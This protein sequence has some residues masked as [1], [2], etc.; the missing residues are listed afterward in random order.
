MRRLR[1][2]PCLSSHP[3]P[4][5]CPS[6]PSHSQRRVTSSTRS[7]RCRISR[8]ASSWPPSAAPALG[9]TASSDGAQGGA[10]PGGALPPG[11]APGR[12]AGREMGC[13]VR[14][15]VDPARLASWLA[16]PRSPPRMGR[17]THLGGRLWTPF[18]AHLARSVASCSCHWGFLEAF[19]ATRVLK[20]PCDRPLRV[21]ALAGCHGALCDGK[22]PVWAAPPR[23]ALARTSE[24]RLAQFHAGTDN[25]SAFSSQRRARL[26]QR[27]TSSRR[28][29]RG[30]RPR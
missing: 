9:P 23:W 26:A 18:S 22:A 10:P 17:F 2:A 1:R 25:G 14:P 24:L 15:G 20:S 28:T 13:P 5:R 16:A 11:R 27:D 6:L 12:A 7:R 8:P 30:A 19:R 21:M 29:G 4:Q 3:P